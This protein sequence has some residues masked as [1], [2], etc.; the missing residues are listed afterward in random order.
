MNSRCQ[1]CIPSF[2]YV[3]LTEWGSALLAL[4]AR[5][6]AKF[7]EVDIV[8]VSENIP[9]KIEKMYKNIRKKVF[10]NLRRRKN[11][12]KEKRVTGLEPETN[13]SEAH[14]LDHWANAAN[15][16][17]TVKNKIYTACVI[18]VRNT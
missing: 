13:R 15:R 12:I 18:Y 9:F 8:P 10:K 3:F 11:S 6:W 2:P 16:K 5:A 4:R 7:G 17:I 14:D 1:H